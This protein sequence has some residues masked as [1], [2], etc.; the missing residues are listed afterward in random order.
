MQ[1]GLVL[2][3]M[4]LC[5]SVLG[6]CCLLCLLLFSTVDECAD[7]ELAELVSAWGHDGPDG[8]KEDGAH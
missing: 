6:V 1:D 4:T 8:F 7:V 3:R 2:Q 5:P